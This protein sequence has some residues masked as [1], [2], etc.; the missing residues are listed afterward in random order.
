MN[1]KSVG[2][3]NQ[4]FSIVKFLTQQLTQWQNRAANLR[5][6]GSKPLGGDGFFL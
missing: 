1:E 3:K 5:V 2:D 4:S 6:A